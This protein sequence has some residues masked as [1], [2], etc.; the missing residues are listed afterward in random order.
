[1]LVHSNRVLRRL[2]VGTITGDL[3]LAPQSEE[4]LSI[5]GPTTPAIGE[6]IPIP[7]LRQK[8]KLSDA[9]LGLPEVEKVT[10]LVTGIALMDVNSRRR[11]VPVFGI[12]PNTYFSVLDDIE[13]TG[14]RALKNNERGVML[15]ESHL[16]RITRKTGS[17][18]EFGDE[19]LFTSGAGMRFR[20]RGVP[21]VG[22][23]RY[24][25]SMEYVDQI[26][27]LDGETL[28]ALNSI[29]HRIVT[30]LPEDG[31]TA[32]PD[33]AADVD[34]LFDGVSA[35]ETDEQSED[36]PDGITADDVLDRVRTDR[37]D[38]EEP[39]DGS[40]HFL[41]V[42]GADS[43]ELHALADRFGAEV[44]SWRQ[45]AG[46]SALL[47]L[48]LQ[49]LFNGGFTL[50]VLAIALGSVNIIFISTYR[51]MRE[52]G[53]LRAIGTEDRLVLRIF[54]AE[55]A[56]IGLIGWLAG[57][58][59]AVGFSALLAARRITVDNRLIAMLLGGQRITLPLDT[60]TIFVCLAVVICL[61]GV[62]VSIPLSRAMRQPIVR[63]IREAG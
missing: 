44:L 7:L 45:A 11:T 46:Q 29:Q 13:I 35:A 14:G 41:L 59:A 12:E 6:F 56:F 53:T 24:P 4:S 27:L 18:V 32:G 52:I 26:A 34:S 40:A 61:V 51:R 23:F 25:V 48:L 55:H 47:A 10:P 62:T 42:R 19:I 3:V 30:S 50:F 43:E 15:T 39:A 57:L 9:V 63:S 38:E 5:F 49:I 20:I 22:V 21:L 60:G 8:D 16:N 37:G 28:R 17:P 2:F 33:S 36:G 1:M 31:K 58:I 54:V